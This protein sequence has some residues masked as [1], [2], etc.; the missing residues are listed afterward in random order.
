MELASDGGR[1]FTDDATCE[2]L[3][4]WGVKH[5]LSSAYHPQAN[6]RAEVAIKSA[7]RL[8]RSN[9]G[10]TGTLDYARFLRALL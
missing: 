8:L 2:F 10:P 9:V 4:R 6:G 5:K 7:K 3:R 1:E